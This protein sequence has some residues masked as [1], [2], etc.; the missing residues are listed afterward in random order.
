MRRLHVQPPEH[1]V[2][3]DEEGEA[4]GICWASGSGEARGWAP[5]DKDSPIK[6]ILDDEILLCQL[7][8]MCIFIIV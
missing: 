3:E 6:D 7:Y 8:Y 4:P 2:A 5:L 1:G